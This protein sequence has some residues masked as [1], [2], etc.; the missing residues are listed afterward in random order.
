MSTLYVAFPEYL[1]YSSQCYTACV[2]FSEN[3]GN[4]NQNTHSCS[5]YGTNDGFIQF[6]HKAGSFVWWSLRI[7]WLFLI[8]SISDALCL[9]F[10]Y[11]NLYF[12]N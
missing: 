3:L 8:F 7:F 9:C 10:V 11:K 5:H 4:S 1:G 2:A 6:S 12:V